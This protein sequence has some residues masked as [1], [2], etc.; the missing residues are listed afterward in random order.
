[1]KKIKVALFGHGFLG[2]WHAEKAKGLEESELVLIVEP[3]FQNHEDL[4]RRYPETEIVTSWQGHESKFEAALIVTPTSFHFQLCHELIAIG[5]HIFCEKPVTS[6]YSEALKLSRELKP[7]Q[8]FQV[9]HS[10]RCHKVWEDVRL[11][12]FFKSS[13]LLIEVSRQ[14]AFKARATDVD[15]VQDLMI[16]DIDL[17][18][19]LME[20]KPKSL[21]SL[22]FKI[23]T[24][25]W[26]H[27]KTQ[28]EFS[29]QK[30]V[31]IHVGRNAACEER[32]WKLTSKDGQVFIDLLR[33]E[34]RF[35]DNKTET[36]SVESYEKRDH[37]LL[38]QKSFYKSILSNIPPMVSLMDGVRAVYLV[39]ESL[40]SLI[41]SGPKKLDFR[42]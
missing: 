4:K 42:E 13:E 8:V 27:V 21:S 38:E 1:V 26:D 29:P 6:T 40:N 32:Y 39:E 16:H 10:E 30:R 18:L 3:Q 23:R 12:K 11:K 14:S 25:T 36:T 37:L 5:K 41:S 19:W 7:G 9:G 24:Q 2:K 28:F 15:V 20:E 33:N 35:S 31:E 22:G 34:I 17:M